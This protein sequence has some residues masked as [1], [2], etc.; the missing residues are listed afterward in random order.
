MKHYSHKTEVD[1]LSELYSKT[2]SYILSENYTKLLDYSTEIINLL[3]YFNENQIKRLIYNWKF[4]KQ[5]IWEPSRILKDP[6]SFITWEDRLITFNKAEKI[7]TDLN[8]D[9][10]INTHTRA[11]IIHYFSSEGFY[12]EQWKI[13]KKY[14]ECFSQIYDHN[15]TNSTLRPLLKE[16]CKRNPKTKQL[17]KYYTTLELIQLEKTIGNDILDMYYTEDDSI[18]VDKLNALNFIANFENNKQILLT[19][20]QKNCI[21]NSLKHK[22]NII[23][24]YPGTGK[25]TITEVIINYMMDH[26]D[27]N[28]NNIFNLAPTG[29]AMKN[30]M[31]KCGNNINKQNGMTLHKFILY[32]NNLKHPDVK[33][34]PENNRLI[35]T[36]KDSKGNI[37]QISYYIPQHIN[38]DE[39]SMMDIFIFQ[40]IINICK[41]Y[42]CSLT[43]I[44]DVN[45]IA[46]IKQP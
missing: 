22:F 33:Q 28:K 10:K 7:R 21:L 15:V 14:I 6:F 31:N 35:K 30:L 44:G 5:D 40:K 20:E 32:M 39:A 1:K 2:A 8:I 3:E 45:G 13:E 16:Y 19:D 18:Y 25:S 11:W 42:S 38:I 46:P 24:G 43:L 17:V 12:I 34:D 9:T 29:L 26:M 23:N 4:K 37:K 41:K 36:Y 27:Y